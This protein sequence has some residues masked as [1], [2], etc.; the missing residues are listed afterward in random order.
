MSS[1]SFTLQRLSE[2]CPHL[3][4]SE[5]DLEEIEEEDTPRRVGGGG[6]TMGSACSISSYHPTP[7]HKK[8]KGN[9]SYN[10]YRKESLDPNRQLQPE[11]SC[12]PYNQEPSESN[13]SLQPLSHEPVES[14][15]PLYPPYPP[16]K[17]LQ[18]QQGNSRSGN[19]V[20]PKRYDFVDEDDNE[21]Q[22]EDQDDDDY[23]DVA[24]PPIPTRSPMRRLPG[25]RIS[26]QRG[27]FPVIPWVSMLP[28]KG[29]GEEVE[30]VVCCMNE[31][32]A[33]KRVI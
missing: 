24:P 21:D 4:E 22:N 25:R 14:T 20:D 23:V 15:S 6:E 29:L 8:S 3:T 30:V 10:P 19:F 33:N 2:I 31:S 17:T 1:P 5:Q 13:P 26:S 16:W 11:Y 27:R 9:Y 7:N 18:Q 12:N 32:L 28:F